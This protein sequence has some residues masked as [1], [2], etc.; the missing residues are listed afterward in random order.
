MQLITGLHRIH[1]IRYSYGWKLPL[2]K[3]GYFGEKDY[4]KFGFKRLDG[5]GK[6]YHDCTATGVY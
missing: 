5:R 4:K 1:H 6:D 2:L 3:V